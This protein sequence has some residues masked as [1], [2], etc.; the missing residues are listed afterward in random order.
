M[1]NKFYLFI[2]GLLNDAVSSS[3]FLPS[4]DNEL[5]RIWKEAAVA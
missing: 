4:N 1:V 2:C 5:E 3:D